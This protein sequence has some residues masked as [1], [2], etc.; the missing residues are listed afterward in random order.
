MRRFIMILAII[1]AAAAF[2]TASAVRTHYIRYGD[3]LWELAIRYYDNPFYWEDILEANPQIEGVEYL[4]PGD[5][6]VIPDIYGNIIS[7][8]Y[9]QYSQGAYTTSGISRVPQLSR[10]LLETTGMVTTDSPQAV[11]YVVETDL[12]REYQYQE[13]SSYAGDIMAIDIGGDQGVEVDRVYKIYKMG[14]EVRHPRTGVLMGNV[15]RVAGVCR[16]V[17]TAPASSIVLLE[18]SY[19]PVDLGDFLVPYTSIAP[20]AVNSSEVVSEMDAWVLALQNPELERAYSYDVVFIDRGSQDGLNPGDVFSLFEYGSDV[21]SPSGGT[22]TTPDLQLAN[23]IILD[24]T[25]AT[26]AA[27]IFDIQS[28]DLISP[29]ERLELTRKQP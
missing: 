25:P 21:I 6:I 13:Y 29:G 28:L 15:I 3:T 11:G 16:V 19:L 2:T 27:M 10:L 20:V 5:E 14:E 26:S 9:Q 4:Y 18:H 22:V 8:D 1:V 17:E 7:T 12:A 23:L 24:T